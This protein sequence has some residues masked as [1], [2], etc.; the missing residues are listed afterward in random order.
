[1][2]GE[3]EK[4]F[5][6]YAIALSARGMNNGDGGPFGSIVVKGDEIVGEGW[7]QVLCNS[8]PT[9]HAE[10]MAIRDACRR[11]N[12]FQLDGCEI[13]T[14]CEPC[15]M[16]LGAIYWARPAKVYFANTKEDAAAIAFDDSFIYREMQLPLEARKIPLVHMPSKAALEVFG[17]WKEKENRTLY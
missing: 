2:I 13:Y 4:K 7:N 11:L 5:M 12:S 8:D 10:V 3:R 16:C 15:P 1:M 14:S 17:Q 6:D 9:A